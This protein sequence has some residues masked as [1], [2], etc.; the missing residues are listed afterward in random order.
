MA[1]FKELLNQTAES[2]KDTEEYK[3]LVE[4]LDVVKAD[5]ESSRA[6][7]EF[8]DAQVEIQQIQMTGQ[9][10]TEDQIKKWQ[11]IT[12]AAQLLEPIKKLSEAENAVNGLLQEANDALTDPLNS[13]YQ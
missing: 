5:E 3:N 4:A 9:Q 1:N 2:L 13:L 10:P 8:Q 11:E 6:F 12:N 7:A